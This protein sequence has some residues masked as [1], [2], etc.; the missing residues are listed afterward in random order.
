MGRQCE[1]TTSVGRR[2]GAAPMHDR[3]YCFLHDPAETAR[4]DEA[5]RLGGARR[6]HESALETV[7]DLPA[8]NTPAGL[9]RLVEIAVTDALSLDAGIGRLRVLLAGVAAGTR[10]LET[11][12]LVRRI[13]A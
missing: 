2:C 10:L 3:P 1:V 5:R 9:T 13:E 11:T 4:A 12:D 6:R 7:Y 8:L